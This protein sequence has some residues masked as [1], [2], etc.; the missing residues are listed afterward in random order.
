MR[1]CGPEERGRNQE[2]RVTKIGRAV[3]PRRTIRSKAQE[4]N[5][6]EIPELSTQNF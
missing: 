3:K 1:G 2:P 4:A 5:C 6:T